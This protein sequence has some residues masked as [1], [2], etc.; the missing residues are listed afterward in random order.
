MKIQVIACDRDREVPART[1]EITVSDGRTVKA[2]LCARHAEPIEAL[3]RELAGEQPAE[4]AP[5]KAPAR[6]SSS[7]RRP[8]ITTLEEIEAQKKRGGGQSG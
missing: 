7:R 5:A 6:K 1:Y 4:E 8:V 3:I 2:D